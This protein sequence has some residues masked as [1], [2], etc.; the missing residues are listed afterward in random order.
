MHWYNHFEKVWPEILKKVKQFL[1]DPAT[2]LLGVKFKR[3]KNMF[4]KTI[5]KKWRQ[6]KCPPTSE[7]IGKTQHIRKTERWSAIKRV[8]IKR[9]IWDTTW[10]TP[11]TLCYVKEG[12]HRR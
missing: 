6:P 9:V 3:T 2:I 1:Y 4:T 12:R 5:A 7:Q 10:I 11:K 8:N